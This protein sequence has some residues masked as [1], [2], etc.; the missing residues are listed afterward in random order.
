MLV[1]AV[2]CRDLYEDSDGEVD[3]ADKQK[4]LSG[5]LEWWEVSAHAALDEIRISIWRCP[6]IF[7]DGDEYDETEEEAVG[8]EVVMVIMQKH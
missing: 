7:D 3:R 4:L 1:V 8:E 5:V 6:L 2:Q